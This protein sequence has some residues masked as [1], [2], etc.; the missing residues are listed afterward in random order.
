MEVKDLSKPLAVV[1]SYKNGYDSYITYLSCPSWKRYWV[2][3]MKA[4]NIAELKNNL[5]FYLKKVKAGQELV[6]KDRNQPIAKL[7]PL[8]AEPEDDLLLLASEGKL[9]LGT[10]LEDDFWR[11]PA[12]QVS[13]AAIASAVRD[14]RADD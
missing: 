3:V 1:M 9:K 4:V 2:D 10:H 7:V 14:D 11:L 8:V 12:P 13:S 5:S 6:V